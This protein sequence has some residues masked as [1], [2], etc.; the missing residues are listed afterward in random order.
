[1]NKGL[2]PKIYNSFAVP[3]DDNTIIR[4]GTA[5]IFNLRP[6]LKV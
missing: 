4:P 2:V 6:E 1:M 3:S 5:L